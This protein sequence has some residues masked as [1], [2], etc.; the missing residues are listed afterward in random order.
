[1]GEVAAGFRLP[2]AGAVDRRCR[3]AEEASAGV[4]QRHRADQRAHPLGVASPHLRQGQ[5]HYHRHRQSD[6][7]L[8]FRKATDVVGL[9]VEAVV[10]AVRPDRCGLPP[11][12]APFAPPA[13]KACVAS[14]PD[15]NG[16]IPGVR[17]VAN[18]CGVVRLLS[19]RGGVKGPT[20]GER[21]AIR[22]RGAALGPGG[23]YRQGAFRNADA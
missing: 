18:V 13:P 7:G 16:A 10:E 17:S 9:E 19:R 3:K 12:W 1:M 22:M 4:A 11:D 5:R 2:A 15:G 21:P 23:R 6:A 14:L 20:A 8:H